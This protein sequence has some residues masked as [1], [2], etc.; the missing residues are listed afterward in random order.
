MIAG[1]LTL[2]PSD[3][4]GLHTYLYLLSLVVVVMVLVVYGYSKKAPMAPWLII[5]FT[6]FLFSIIGGKIMA[7]SPQEWQSI[8]ATFEFPETQRKTV[9]G[10]F[11]FGTLGFYLS[12]WFLRF[13]SPISDAFAFAWPAGLLITRIG[14]LTGGCCHGTVTDSVL[15]I[16]YSKG[17]QAF[18]SHLHQGILPQDATMSLAIHP[19]QLYEILFCIVLLGVLIYLSR[20]KVLKV[21][22]NLFFT[23][24][25]FYGLFRFFTEFIR[26]DGTE[27]FAG[28]KTVQLAVMATAIGMAAIIWLR[29]RNRS[30]TS[31]KHL[32]KETPHKLIAGAVLPVLLLISVSD[33]LT[34]TELIFLQ[35]LSVSS[36]LTT[37]CFILQLIPKAPLKFAPALMVTS[38]FMLMSQTLTEPLDSAFFKRNYFTLK[39]AGSF[40]SEVEICGGAND[41][42]SVGMAFEHTKQYDQYKKLSFGSQAYVISY[43]SEF[44]PGINPYLKMDWKYFG[45]GLGINYSKLESNMI[46]EGISPTLSLRLGREDVFFVDGH[47]GGYFPAVVPAFRMGL[48]IGSRNYPG[49]FV[50]FGISE[51]GFYLNPHILVNQNFILDPFL[52]YGDKDTYHVGLRLHFRVFR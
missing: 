33:W 37:A 50:R 17:S 20:R 44:Y 2:T 8:L 28:I 52:S 5:L 41:Y 26:P 36:L 29:E 39:S 1:W 14:C 25:M 38:A 13:N 40:G 9:L 15:G 49:S 16:N 42:K 4:G 51:A 47:Y 18:Y 10:Y 3:F 46:P 48:G 24:I 27:A 6:T 45:T 7:Y 19:V 30:G 32:D 35:V 21:E 31:T 34:P 22:G 12:K 11:L 23:S 43:D